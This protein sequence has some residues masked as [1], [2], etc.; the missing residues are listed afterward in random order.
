MHLFDNP[1]LGLFPWT[2]V[3]HS[4]I[5]PLGS[6]KVPPAP[7]RNWESAYNSVQDQSF[8]ISRYIFTFRRKSYSELDKQ[9]NHQKQHKS[10]ECVE[11]SFTGRDLEE[12]GG[13]ISV[14]KCPG[15]MPGIPLQGDTNQ[16]CKT[17]FYFHLLL[18]A[19]SRCQGPRA[20]LGKSCQFRDDD[21]S[22]L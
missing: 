16:L 21:S 19:Y 2:G 6:S 11:K 4:K 10:Q 7:M 13:V 15:Q 20:L 17:S 3:F 5:L 12:R 22:L 18:V 1:C 9:H 8:F 14:A